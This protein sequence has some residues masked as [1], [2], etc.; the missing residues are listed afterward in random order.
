MLLFSAP[1][2]ATICAWLSYTCADEIPFLDETV[3]KAA[4]AHSFAGDLRIEA[5]RHACS[6]WKVPAGSA[7]FNEPVR[8][9]APVLIISG[10]DDPATPPRYGQQAAVYLPNA[11]IVLVA[12]AGHGADTPCTDRLKVQFVRAQSAKELDTTKCSASFALPHFATSLPP[13]L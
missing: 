11:K 12:G 3:V 8:S 6:I 9:N 13:F 10:S 5:Q 2:L 4:A 1:T 7:K